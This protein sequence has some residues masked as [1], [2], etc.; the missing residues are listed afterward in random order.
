MTEEENAGKALGALRKTESKP[1]SGCGIVFIGLVKKTI[2]NPCK[3]KIYLK[4]H[5]DKLKEENK[6]T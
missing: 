2:C 6:A 1:C 5:R 3:N 4:R